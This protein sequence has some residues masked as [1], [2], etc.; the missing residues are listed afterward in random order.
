MTSWLLLSIEGRRQYAGNIGYSDITGEVYRYDSLVPNSKHVAPGDIA[1]F[2]NREGA[3]GIAVTSDVLSEEGTKTIQRCPACKAAQIKERTTKSP[4]YR[5]KHGHEFDTPDSEARACTLYT[6]RFESYVPLDSPV[7]P[8]TLRGACKN[9]NGQ[10]S[11]QPFTLSILFPFLR[12]V[13]P[14]SIALL[15]RHGVHGVLRPEDGDLEPVPVIR[16]GIVRRLDSE[17]PVMRQI[18]ARRGQT[19][20]RRRLIERYKHCLVTGCGLVDALEAAHIHP[21]RSEADNC[22]ENGLLLRCDIHTLFDLDLLGIEPETL[23]VQLAPHIA[24]HAYDQY[25]G[26]HLLCNETQPSKEAIEFRW[27]LFREVLSSRDV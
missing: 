21:Y 19:E 2:R 26:Q 6:A 13:A 8:Q 18:R 20:F 10:L 12:N 23:I 1:V 24:G 17:M 4:R 5:C 11:I 9:F 27:R 3:F 7:S 22:P 15:D 16:D 25:A 14:D